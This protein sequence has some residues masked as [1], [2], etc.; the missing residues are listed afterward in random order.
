MIALFNLNCVTMF[1]FRPKSH[2]FYESLTI[3]RWY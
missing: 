2:K 1:I 3:N